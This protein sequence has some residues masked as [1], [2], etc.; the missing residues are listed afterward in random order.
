[1]TRLT[2]NDSNLSYG[3]NDKI[4]NWTLCIL[5]GLQN[6]LTSFGSMIGI[7]KMISS[8]VCMDKGTYIT[9][10]LQSKMLRT[11]FFCSGICTLLQVNYGIRLPIV[12][13][14]NVAFF[15]ALSSF[16][17]ALGPDNS[18]GIAIGANKACPK[19][20][21]NE[22]GTFILSDDG[23][24]QYEYPWNPKLQGSEQIF[25][26]EQVSN[27]QMQQLQGVI[28]IGGLIEIL[29]GFSGVIGFLLN[30]VSKLTICVVLTILALSLFKIAT[31]T[32]YWPITA[33]VIILVIVF[34]HVLDQVE[35]KVP[36][37]N[38]K[39]KIF[40]LFPVF[41]SIVITWLVC[42]IGNN[43][44]IFDEPWG[45]DPSNV[46]EIYPPPETAKK[47]AK[48]ATN[49]EFVKNAAWFE[50]PHPFSWSSGQ[51]SPWEFVNFPLS[52]A[53]GMLSGVFASVLESIG[54]YYA[55]AQICEVRKPPKSA[56]NRG[57]FFEGVGTVIGG[58]FGTGNGMTS[59][60]E[61]IGTITITGVA[62]R[63]VCITEAVMLL[64]IG[65]LEKFSSLI[66][67]MPGA[68][69][70][71]VYCTM[72]GMITGV[73]LS[74]LEYVDL[75]KSRNC[76][77]LGISMFMAMAIPEWFASNPGAVDSTILNVLMSNNMFVGGFTCALLDNVLKGY[78]EKREKAPLKMVE[79]EDVEESENLMARTEKIEK[80]VYQLPFTIPKSFQKWPIFKND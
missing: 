33:L 72:F 59:Y 63:I 24:F 13:G 11:S 71:G 38:E 77:I 15:A 43:F 60:S 74:N 3:I 40:K 56:V 65:C 36:G 62:S 79:Q 54:D 47:F 48:P 20:L 18:M 76:L 7:P 28:I 16:L 34:S 1:M 5:F 64:F 58:I 12:Q 46:N 42:I 32:A 23:Q 49:A 44:G 55:L 25:T 14:A 50:M 69:I 31:F 67:S 75:G 4:P 19:E 39:L 26:E 10:K 30:Y 45:E 37:L 57:I 78:S 2:R 66:I 35:V 53:I 17:L 61:N 29:L 9:N 8:F 68:V 73:G 80:D 41:L 51:I 21:T 22:N 70:S 27:H 52:A 6:F